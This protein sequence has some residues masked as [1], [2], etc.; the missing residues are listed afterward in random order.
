LG[1]INDKDLAEILSLFPKNA[2]YYFCRPSIPRGLDA[3]ILKDKSKQFNLI[4]DVYLSVNKA[5]E[6]S[7]KNA[8]SDDVIYIGGSTFVVAEIV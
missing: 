7:Q 2:T 1:V 8:S 5:F 4:G 6:S 3:T